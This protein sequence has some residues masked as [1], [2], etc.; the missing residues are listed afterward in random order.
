MIDYDKKK[1]R[2]TK[3][4]QKCILK[5]LRKKILKTKLKNTFSLIDYW[6]LKNTNNE[7]K[8]KLNVKVTYPKYATSTCHG[9]EQDECKDDSLTQFNWLKHFV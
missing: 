6:L 3:I 4:Y 5:K 9:D 7:R 1:I 8:K 2:K